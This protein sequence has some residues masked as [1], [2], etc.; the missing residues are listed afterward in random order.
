[1]GFSLKKVTKAVTAPVR[2]ATKPLA[3]VAKV[4]NPVTSMV[5]VDVT[6]ATNYADNLAAWKP[7]NSNDL[8][9][10]LVEGGKIAAIAATGGGAMG[11]TAGA[12]S[13]MALNSLGGNMSNSNLLSQA[14][15]AYAA[16]QT[17]DISAMANTSLA[18]SLGNLFEKKVK[19]QSTPIPYA[20]PSAMPSY[21]APSKEATPSPFKK[22]LAI[23]GGVVALLIVGYFFFRKR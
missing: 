12:A 21:V 20:Q 3:E 5:G 22:Y 23:G 2:V 8:K 7:T 18:S 10:A 9:S 11:L 6:K 13:L 1:M 4:V 15:E 19:T 14:S 17:G 16:Y